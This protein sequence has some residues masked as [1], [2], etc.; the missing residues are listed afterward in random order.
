M[1]IT[2]ILKICIIFFFGFLS[3]NLV[4]FYLTY[5][6]EN[7]F[8]EDFNFANGFSSNI[9]PFNFIKE[10]Q[11]HVYDDK[12][13]I[14]VKEASISRYA[15]TGSMK[16]TFDENA[17][18][19][20]IVPVS[21]EDVHIGDIITFNQGENLIVHRIIDKGT[22]REGVYFITR[23]DNN[24]VSDGKIRFKDIKSIT[25]GVIW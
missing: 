19:I 16:P 5:G 4:S 25:I 10:D 7:P 3:A 12:I 20:K 1:D 17:N 13:V 18:G 15:P 2:K 11:I 23:G 24:S 6:L 21:E 9:A 22:D 14:N 8:S